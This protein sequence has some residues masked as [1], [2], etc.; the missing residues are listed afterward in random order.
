MLRIG[1]K[2]LSIGCIAYQKIP[3]DHMLKLVDKAVDFSFINELLADSYCRDMGRPAKE[4]AMMA[5]ILFLQFLYDLSDVRVIEE[6]TYNLVW[7]WFLGLNPEDQLPDPSLLAKFRTQRLSEYNLDD[8]ITEIVRQCVEKGLIEGRGVSI[9]ATHIRANTGKLIP[10]RIMKHLAKR[11]FSALENDLGEIPGEID[12]RIPDWTEAANHKQAKEMMR[13][14]L[15]KVMDKAM[16]L[17]GDETRKAIAESKEVLSD[18][19]FILQKGI[20]SLVDKDARVGAKSKTDR[21]FGY[22]SEFM[23]TTDERIITAIHT[24]SGEYADGKEFDPLLGKT[25]KADIQ[26]KEIFGDKAYFRKDILDSIETIGAEALIPVSASAYRINEQRFSYNK[27]SDQWFCVMGNHTVKKKRLTRKQHGKTVDIY[28]YYFDGELC[29]GCPQRKE[30]M[31]KAKTKGRKLDVALHTAKFY[32]ISQHQKT[33]EFKE[34][35]KKRAAQEWKNAEM[36]RFHGLA[37]ARGY[38]LR[39]VSIQAKLTAIAVNLKRIAALVVEKATIPYL[40]LRFKAGFLII[41][42]GDLRAA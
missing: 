24:K 5:K 34:R 1:N 22:K 23:M 29:V 7:L 41:N 20:R 16:P 36:K 14:Y 39:S 4:P 6:A 31:G 10:E 33:P 25:V 26:P 40:K 28:R 11:I 13:M 17:A 38:G 8:I 37:R 2:Q 12:T 18:E 32:A 35:Y 27:D 3:E 30:C 9:D 19:R 21:F 42:G 15:E